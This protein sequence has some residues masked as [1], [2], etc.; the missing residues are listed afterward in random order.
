MGAAV[1]AMTKA[2][3][4]LLGYNN[5]VRHKNRVFHIQTED[6]GVK[7]PHIIT[8]LFMD[9]GRILKSVKTSY[10]DH[11]EAEKLQDFVK[12]LMKDQHKAMFKALRDG[13]FDKLL[14]DAGSQPNLAA[15]KARAA[16]AT[17]TD[18]A[19]KTTREPE[20]AAIPIAVVAPAAVNTS[21]ELTLDLDA[22]DRAA[23]ASI[24]PYV[25]LA[26]DLPPPPAQL[27]RE[28]IA[29]EPGTG[30]YR[31]LEATEE[32]LP[33]GRAR[34][35]KSERPTPKSERPPVAKSEK[36]P[37]SERSPASKSTVPAQ[38]SRPPARRSERPPPSEAPVSV[39]EENFARKRDPRAE[40][41]EA[42]PASKADPRFA[43]A[44]P[45]AIFG[46]ARPQQGSSIFGEDIIS[47]K[48][49]DEVILS[50]LAEDLDESGSK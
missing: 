36:P 30:R 4:P 34:A 35:P 8:H 50:Y 33:P 1:I 23:E 48:S 2:N 12:Q 25:P 42:K 26:H 21:G 5:N 46:Q 15:V 27:M 29:P 18:E 13:Q 19:P 38:K 31:A 39:R 49:L 9:G 40:P 41:S 32:R 7:H 6:S 47:D 10:K 28:R 14:E 20:R 24:D 37:R 43:P 3:S 17:I 45:A 44:R 11:L 16:Q 22:L